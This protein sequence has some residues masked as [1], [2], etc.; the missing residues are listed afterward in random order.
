MQR[1]HNDY[2]KRKGL[3]LCHK[4]TRIR[5]LPIPSSRR[6]V[7][8]FAK[9]LPTPKPTGLCIVK[10][11]HGFSILVDPILGKGLE[12]SIF[13]NGTY[14]EG[15]LKIMNGILRDEDTFID[16]GAN[17]GLMSLHAAVILNGRGKVLSFEPLSSTYN[18]LMQNIKLNNLENIEAV[19]MAIGSTNGI[20]DI[21]DNTIINRGSSSIIKPH[22]T[23]A[24]HRILIK[25]L[26]TYLE[27]HHID[28]ITCIK[29]DVEGWELE[30][31]KG[32]ANTLSG[33]DAP[34][35]IVECSTLHPTYG[36]DN[37]DIYSFLC[38][39]NSYRLFRLIGGKER[40]SKLIE[41]ESKDDLP[42]HDNLFCFLPE[43][44]KRLPGRIFN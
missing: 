41:I 16:I 32:A 10:T 21:W 30:V 14:E 18:L 2:S 5:N 37:R 29:I 26:D 43:H 6:I 39:I 8:L 25:C 38:N 35:C 11:L 34:I 36:G 44:I 23:A 40:P 22:Q 24:G 17:I 33:A 13:F 20:V 28:S 12:R 9:L 27:E 3:N 4:L 1:E 31:L 15:T 7:S 42:K 19:N